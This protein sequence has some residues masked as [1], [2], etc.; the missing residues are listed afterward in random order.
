LNLNLVLLF[1][2]AGIV[3]YLAGRFSAP[4]RTKVETVTLTKEVQVQDESK[5]VNQIQRIVETTR[6]DGTTV[7]ETRI[8]TR[9]ASERI[10]SKTTEVASKESREIENRRGVNVSALIGLPLTEITKGPVYGA[11]ISKP[12]IGPIT[13]GVWGLTNFTFGLSV[14]L[15]L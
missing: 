10:Q 1:I 4:E 2:G 13:L 7:K 9:A 12:F 11:S 3:G 15:E 5:R 14:G 8:K 6:P